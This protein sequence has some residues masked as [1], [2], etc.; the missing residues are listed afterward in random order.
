MAL[1]TGVD[2]ALVDAALL[3]IDQGC[4]KAEGDFYFWAQPGDLDKEADVRKA[5]SIVT[6]VSELSAS[7]QKLFQR[8]ARIVIGGALRVA[9]ERVPDF[10][11]ESLADGAKG[12]CTKHYYTS[13]EALLEESKHLKVFE[14]GLPATVWGPLSIHAEV[15]AGL[16][17]MFVSLGSDAAQLLVKVMDFQFERAKES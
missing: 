5:E 2:S 9:L 8:S 15:R 17:D 12:W 13:L 7:E 14:D 6:K 11:C 16:K 4:D 1:A 10:L 3:F